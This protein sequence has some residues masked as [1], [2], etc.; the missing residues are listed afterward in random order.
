MVDNTKHHEKSMALIVIGMAGSGKTT[1]V[2][3]I[4]NSYLTKNT[5]DVPY[6]IN[7]DPAV[8]FTPYVPDFDI[9]KY[10][11]QKEVMKKYKLGPNGAIMTCLNLF[12]ANIVELISAIEKRIA[13]NPAQL[14]VIDTPGQI[15]AFNWSASGQIIST[16]IARILPTAVLF[17]VDKTRTVN[18]N[19]FMSNMLFC[20]SILFKMRL[21]LMV[22]FNKADSE[23][24]DRSV[25]NWLQNY[26]TFLTALREHTSA[27]IN[28]LSRSLCLALDTFYKDLPYAFVSSLTGIGLES[29]PEA[30]TRLRDTYFE[31]YYK[32]LLEKLQ[33]LKTRSSDNN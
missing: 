5:E 13:E 19:A 29:I 28:S 11:S 10:H 14:F 27:Y 17:I 25:E 24:T 7:L 2:N 20:V 31:V 3:G 6:I 4:K 32:D 12:A 21:P 15:E 33:E 8:F 9:R 30:V 23:P 22:M 1:F 18:P 16:A 26:D